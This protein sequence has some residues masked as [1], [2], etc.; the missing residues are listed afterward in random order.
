MWKIGDHNLRC[1]EPIGTRKVEI[2]LTNSNINKEDDIGSALK[3]S[4]LEEQGCLKTDTLRLIR[5]QEF[6]ESF[7]PCQFSWKQ[8]PVPQLTIRIG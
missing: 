6:C 3:K 5:F 1:A 8:E 4:Q 7:S 2:E